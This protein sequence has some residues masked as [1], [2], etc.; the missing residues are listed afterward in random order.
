MKRCLGMNELTEKI[1][2]LIYDEIDQMEYEYSKT[3]RNETINSI[4]Q[5]SIALKNVSEVEK[6]KHKE[7]L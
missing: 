6:N 2:K 3:E 7:E 5:L 4:L 1:K